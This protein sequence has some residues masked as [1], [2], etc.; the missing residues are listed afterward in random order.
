M[1]SRARIVGISLN[2]ISL[3]EQGRVIITNKEI[4]EATKQ[5]KDKLDSEDKGPL[6]DDIFSVNVGFC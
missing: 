2:E 1:N 3:D 5:L 4:I 6:F